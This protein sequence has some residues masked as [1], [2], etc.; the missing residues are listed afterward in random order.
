MTSRLSQQ[1]H[2]KNNDFKQAAQRALHGV[3]L[4]R[5][6]PS[7]ELFSEAAAGLLQSLPSEFS[8][9]FKKQF[10]REITDANPCG[11]FLPRGSSCL[12]AGWWIGMTQLQPG[13]GSG[14][15]ATEAFHRQWQSELTA[16]GC[17]DT[18][19]TVFDTMQKLYHTWCSTVSRL[20]TDDIST[21]S[22]ANSILL[23]GSALHRLGRGTAQE[24]WLAR[25]LPN[26]IVMEIE[27]DHAVI[28]ARDVRQRLHEEDARAALDIHSAS[29][30]A[31]RRK[32]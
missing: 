27:D 21:N 28:V 14:N 5:T 11:F 30:V 13:S 10:F 9:Y 8:A 23:H 7:L 16:A 20:S 22:D 25:H 19:S 17:R 2:A 29:G 24:G 31:L 3:S 32:L 12:A 15:Q 18:F 26:H 6:A 4:I 1:A